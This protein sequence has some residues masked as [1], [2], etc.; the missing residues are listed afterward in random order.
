M[1]EHGLKRASEVGLDQREAGKRTVE[2]LQ[3]IAFRLIGAA[4]FFGLG[5]WLLGKL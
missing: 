3:A 2:R 4:L 1:D 5:G